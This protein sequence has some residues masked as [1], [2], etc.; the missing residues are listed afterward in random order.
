VR[1]VRD[2]KISAPN[3]YDT[4]STACN[5]RLRS[6][7]DG[8]S[9]RE[10]VKAGLARSRPKVLAGPIASQ[11]VVSAWDAFVNW[12]RLHNRELLAAEMESWGVMA[13]VYGK[14][15]PKRSLI[16]RGIS[17]FG[18]IRKGNFD[19]RGTGAIRR[20]AARNCID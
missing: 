14:A 15:D 16:I 1:T 5:R 4:W 10:L 18:D 13:S 3:L 6:A 12:L 11:P 2:L 8:K 19:R 7:S 9:L 17:D 20:L